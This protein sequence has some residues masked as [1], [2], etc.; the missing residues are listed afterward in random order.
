MKSYTLHYN[1]VA[2]MLPILL[3]FGYINIINNIMLLCKCKETRDPCFLD[4][5]FRHRVWDEVKMYVISSV[6]LGLKRMKK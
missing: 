1:G 5:D 6:R 3:P 4:Y 2:E